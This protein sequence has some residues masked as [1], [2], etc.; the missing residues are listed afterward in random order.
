MDEEGVFKWNH[1]TIFTFTSWYEN[2]PD[3]INSADCAK[4]CRNGHWDDVLFDCPNWW[5]CCEHWV[6]AT[7]MDE[8]GVFK[9]N[10]RTIFTF[11]SWYENQPDN[12]NSADCAKVCRNGHWDD[13]L[14]EDPNTFICE[15]E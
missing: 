2:Q 11:T 1:R 12:I 8:E 13:V 9:W 3:N 5:D 6:G 14:C 15:K 7:D 4:V 10:H